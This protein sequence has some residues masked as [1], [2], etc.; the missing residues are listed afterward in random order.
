MKARLLRLSEGGAPGVA[1]TLRLTNAPHQRDIVKVYIVTG[2]ARVMGKLAGQVVDLLFELD[3]AGTDACVLCSDTEI[4]E[5]EIA[6][7]FAP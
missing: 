5:D 6:R 4:G 2:D 7:R 3:H 1:D